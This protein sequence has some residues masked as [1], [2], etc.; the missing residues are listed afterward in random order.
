[1]KSEKPR[2]VLAGFNCH[3]IVIFGDFSAGIVVESM[4][5]WLERPE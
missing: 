3:P 2:A 4:T 5:I 1:M